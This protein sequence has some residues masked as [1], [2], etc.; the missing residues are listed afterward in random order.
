MSTE[1]IH[2][3][4]L[5][6]GRTDDEEKNLGKIVKHIVNNNNKKKLKKTVVLVTGDIADDGKEEQF[7]KAREIFDPLFKNGFDVLTIPGNHDYG[8]NGIHADEKRFKYFKSSFWELENVTYP[9]VKQIGGHCFIGLNSMKAESGFFDGLLA[10]GELGGK[11]INNTLGILRKLDNRPPEQKVILHLHH[12]PFLYP[13]DNTAKKIGDKA[14][15]WL[16]DGDDFMHKISGRVDMLLFGHEHRHL[17]FSHTGI[18]NK[19]RIPII[20]S[21]GKSTKSN[22][23]EQEVDKD[24]KANKNK[25]VAT[26]LLGRIIEI[27]DKGFITYKTID[28]T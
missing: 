2:I 28:F 16:K 22:G 26:G 17:D 6:I 5:H 1:I 11:Q 18:S 15:H 25:T 14:A 12:H 4:D 27:N 7:I 9:H 21:S 10:D 23:K 3:S 20:L 19:Y 24:G 8:W 13:D